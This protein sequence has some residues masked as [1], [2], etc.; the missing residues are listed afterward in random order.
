LKQTTPEIG[1]PSLNCTT[2]N[3][4]PFRFMTNPFLVHTSRGIWAPN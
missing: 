4:T 1:S 3:R 2:S